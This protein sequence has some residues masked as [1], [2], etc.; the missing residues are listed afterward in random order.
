ML[1]GFDNN[2]YWVEL[3]V[4][5]NTLRASLLLIMVDLALPEQY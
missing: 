1:K 5:K 4:G 3:L 2:K